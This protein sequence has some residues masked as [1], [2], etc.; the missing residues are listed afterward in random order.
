MP[1]YQ[2]LPIPRVTP[3]PAPVQ[4]YTPLPHPNGPRTPEQIAASRKVGDRMIA[5]AKARGKD[6]SPEDRARRQQAQQRRE[7]AKVQDIICT[8]QRHNF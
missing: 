8:R 3:R 1:T 5:D 2:P 6:I 4:T 7:Q